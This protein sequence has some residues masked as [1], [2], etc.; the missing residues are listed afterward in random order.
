VFNHHTYNDPGFSLQSPNSFGVITSTL[1]PANR[2]NSAR[3]VQFGLRLD[4]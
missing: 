3:W 1:T 2:T 4:F